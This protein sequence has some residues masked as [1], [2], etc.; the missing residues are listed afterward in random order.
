MYT[1]I[2]RFF[3]VIKSILKEQMATISLHRHHSKDEC[4]EKKNYC[5]GEH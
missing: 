1:V 5:R 2:T 3:G 4:G